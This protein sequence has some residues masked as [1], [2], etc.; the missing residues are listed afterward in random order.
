MEDRG[1]SAT[2]VTSQDPFVRVV[3]LNWNGAD[4]TTRCVE[5]LLE[6]DYPADRL[7]ITVVDNGSI[8]GSI[9]VL[10]RRFTKRRSPLTLLSTGANLGFAEGCNSAMRD[11]DDLDAIALVN[12]DATVEP[13]WLRAAVD[14][15]AT[16]PRIGAVATKMLFDT[17]FVSLDLAADVRA[18][19]TSG[20]RPTVESVRVDGLDVTHKTLWGPGIVSSA[21]H[22]IPL[23][24]IRSFADEASIAVPVWDGATT[25]T[26]ELST[27]RPIS[28]AHGED[29]LS[30]RP[31]WGRVRAEVAVDHRERHRRIN[32]LGTDLTEWC[33]G[34]ERHFGDVDRADLVS[35]EVSGWCGGGVLLRSEYL[36]DV[37]VFD[38]H[39]FAYYEDTDLSWRGRNRG[40][41]T[42]TE[43]RSVLHHVLGGTAGSRWAGFFFLNYRNWL[44]TTLR[45]GS[46]QQIA[47]AFANARHL[48]LPYVRR[49]VTGRLRRLQR[50]DTAIASRWTR[51]FAGVAQ[52]RQRI[53]A[54]RSQ[55]P[56]YLEEP[57][58]LSWPLLPHSSPGTP[59]PRPGGPTVVYV[60]VTETLRAGWRAGIQ[61]VVTEVVA[62]LWIDLD[63][64]EVVPIVWSPLDGSYRRLDNAEV[65]RF[66]DP[67]PMRNHPPAPPAAPHP[68]KAAVG[69]L[70]RVGPMKAA[71]D[72]VRRQRALYRRP[73]A[74]RDLLV[75]DIPAGA[76]F[77][78]L[79]AVW[80]LV[81]APRSELYPRLRANGVRVV[82][83]VHDL[84][85]VTNP[86]WFDPN[87][88]RV[89]AE[90]TEAVAR[91]A[92]VV[93]ANSSHTAGEFERYRDGLG[94]PSDAPTV[95]AVAFGANPAT[96]VG[97]PDAALLDSIEGRRVALVVGT[98]EPRK[99]HRLVLDALDRLEAG[100]FD[101]LA[102]VIVGR[103]GWEID[104]VA[105]E[106]RR[107]AETTD[108]VLWPASV[109]DPTL[110]ALYRRA[111]VV[112][113]PSLTEGFGLPVIEAL[114]RGALVLCSNG[115]ALP[116]AGGDH[117]AYFDPTD[118]DEL[119]TLL[120]SVLTDDEARAELSE[121][122][123]RF[124]VPSWDETTTQIADLFRSL[125]GS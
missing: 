28:V 11:L 101:D 10:R 52:Q 61:R 32:N 31:S 1:A 7:D 56:L 83:L 44:L 80:N 53:V 26:V 29:R 107:R 75:R 54:S 104:D 3:V 6:T 39:F 2:H 95:R 77:F 17:D 63:D 33:E 46:E 18:P 4:L 94:L 117:V 37:G 35:E 115:G 67:P 34:Y 27:N 118:A 116:E 103:Q 81:D 36:R 113:V 24:L 22:S 87:L 20:P 89:F 60:D 58:R 73:D 108:R 45:N 19:A 30:V 55:A 120:R 70:T 21:H 5:S 123:G 84:L 79:D 102:L 78:D 72:T 109:D 88:A 62:R 47:A 64:L 91:H 68:F 119:A 66:L 42:V 114:A 112:V 9:D 99:N 85:P 59:A 93:I 125:S 122:A 74:H 43:P 76:V 12:N 40:W 41:K 121:R 82:T 15:L 97:A 25:I 13:G 48:S 38:P 71:K 110:D 50:P 98:I 23:A 92:D 90:F 86:S 65:A 57:A 69:P 105:D 106:L 124:V 96:A 14:R 8:D 51:V 49:N 100:G 16:D 111:D